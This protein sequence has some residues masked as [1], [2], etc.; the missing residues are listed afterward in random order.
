MLAGHELDY[1]R[2]VPIR[3]ITHVITGAAAKVRRTG[4]DERT[5]FSAGVR[6]FVEIR[7]DADRLR[8]TAID[9]L[10]RAFDR[11]V[12]DDP[13]GGGPGAPG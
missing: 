2:T 12:L 6:H 5:A 4:R 1:Q 10:G 3:G 7:A 8:L 9:Q 13:T 11:V